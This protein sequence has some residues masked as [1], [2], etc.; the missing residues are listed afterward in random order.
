MPP[1]DREIAAAHVTISGRESGIAKAFRAVEDRR[2][3]AEQA[4]KRANKLF[5]DEAKKTVTEVDKLSD[6]IDRN[7]RQIQ[8][9]SKEGKINVGVEQRSLKDLDALEK[10]IER[11]DGKDIDVTAHLLGDME[12]KLF[13]LD[14]SVSR[15]D[16][17][18]IN[19]GTMT[20]F[21]ATYTELG[22]LEKKLD[23]IDGRKV[24]IVISERTRSAL[25]STGLI[26][27][28]IRLKLTLMFAKLPPLIALFAQFDSAAFALAGTLTSLV[29]PLS[30]VIGEVGV[31]GGTLETAAPA[32]LTLYESLGV[33]ASAFA[34][35]GMVIKSNVTE[36][37]KVAKAFTEAAR[38]GDASS[39]ASAQKNYEQLSAAQK[40]FVP[41]QIAANKELESFQT[42]L[43]KP[44][45]RT[46]KAGLTALF[47]TLHNLKGI[48]KENSDI[49][50]GFA[51]RFKDLIGSSRFQSFFKEFF[52]QGG[53][54]VETLER[55][56]LRLVDAFRAIFKANLPNVERF[57]NKIGELAEEFS[58]FIL[59]AEK[60]GELSKFFRESGDYAGK[61]FK[62]I[63]NVG[64][65]FLT[66]FGASREAGGE[67]LDTLVRLTNRFDNWMTD[68]SDSG[69]L[70][71][72]A[73]QSSEDFN[74]IIELLWQIGR[75][76][77]G[78]FKAALPSG[79][80]LIQELTGWFKDL[81]DDINSITGQ[82]GLQE[83]FEESAPVAK[84]LGESLEIIAKG[85]FEISENSRGTLISA[86]EKINNEL[87][88]KLIDLFKRTS[89]T[90]GPILNEIL[91]DKLAIIVETMASA[92]GPV[93]IFLIG[94]REVLS[95]FEA[96]PRPLQIVVANFLAFQTVLRVF[97][98]TRLLDLFASGI[99]DLTAYFIN[100]KAAAKDASV[101]TAVFGAGGLGGTRLGRGIK[102]FKQGRAVA[103]GSRVAV[104]ANEAAILAMTGADVAST[105]GGLGKAGKVGEGIGKVLGPATRS[106]GAFSKTLGI[107]GLAITAI[108]GS[109]EA[110]RTNFLGITDW[111]TEPFEELADA[112]EN[113]LDAVTGGHGAEAMRDL[114]DAFQWVGEK[115]G[116]VLDWTTK[117]IGYIAIKG[118]P[119]IQALVYGIKLFA[120]ALNA[121]A[122]SIRLAVDAVQWLVQAVKDLPGLLGAATAAVG[123]F[124]TMLAT[125]FVAA[126]KAVPGLALDGL[127]KLP[128]VI[129][130]A[131]GLALKAFFFFTVKAPTYIAKGVSGVVR[132]I[133]SFIP[134]AAGAAANFIGAILGWFKRLPGRI[135]GFVKDAIHNVISYFTSSKGGGRRGASAFIS[136]IIEAVSSL[137]GKLFN[138]AK[139]AIR[140]FANGIKNGAHWAV[141]AVKGVAQDVIDFLKEV[142]AKVYEF[143]KNIGKEIGEG[144]KDGIGDISFNIGPVEVGTGGVH[145]AK[146]GPVLGTGSGDSVHAR[147]TPG[148]HVLTKDEVKAAG[149]H[150]AVFALRQMLGGGGQGRGGS[151]AAGG[152]VGIGPGL[153]NLAGS[154]GTLS[155][156]IKSSLRGINALAES[157]FKAYQETVE[158]HTKQAMEAAVKHAE[159]TR[160]KIKKAM[161]E[162]KKE[163]ASET[164]KLASAGRANFKKLSEGA[165]LHFGR[166]KK[167]ATK[168]SKETKD[169]VVDSVAKMAGK[170]FDNM[171][172]MSETTGG[173]FESILG[174]T[175]KILKAFG[176][177]FK[178]PDI[179][180]GDSKSNRGGKGGTGNK[181]GK[182]HRARGGRLNRIWQRF[183]EGGRVMGDM[184]GTLRDVVPA[185]LGKNEAVITPHQEG[186]IEQVSGV[187]GIVDMALGA[188]RTPNYFPF[189]K[190]G[191]GKDAKAS[192]SGYAWRGLSPAGL[193][194][195]IRKV[196]GAVMANFPG[197][198]VTSTTGG[199]HS[200]TSEHYL[201]QAADIAGSSRE[202]EHEAAAWIKRT[203]L[204]KVLSEGIHNPNLSV[205]SGAMVSP[206]F[207][208]A[209]TW[210]GHTTHLHLAV[211]KFIKGAIGG[212]G[213][214]VAPDF[215]GI[216]IPRVK[217]KGGAAAAIAQSA[218]QKVGKAANKYIGRKAGAGAGAD[219]S[220]IKGPVP[221][222]FA[223]VAKKLRSPFRSTLAL[224]EAG[225]AESGMKDLGYGDSSSQGPLQLL[226]STAAG[227]GVSPH[228]VPGVAKL[229][230][231]R[232]FYGKGGAIGLA[233]KTSMPAHQIA[234]AVQG[235]AFSD[236]SNYLAQKATALGL[237]RKFGFRGAAKGGRMSNFA[238]GSPPSGHK[239]V[240]EKAA[241]RMDKQLEKII[242]RIEKTFKDKFANLGKTLI[243]LVKGVTDGAT[244]SLLREY[245]RINQKI[246]Q[247][248]KQSYNELKRFT[249]KSLEFTKENI[250]G[251]AQVVSAIKG[252][253]GLAH[254][255]GPTLQSVEKEH[256]AGL[257]DKERKKF[258]KKSAKEQ[259]E[260]LKKELEDARSEFERMREA[261]KK[262]LK[263]ARASLKN[264]VETIVSSSTAIYEAFQSYLDAG[265]NLSSASVSS[266]GSTIEAI[267]GL[268]K[269]NTKDIEQ[270]F[271]R[272]G[273]Y[274]RLIKD[275]GRQFLF[276]RQSVKLSVRE[277]RDLGSQLKFI[278]KLS[279]QTGTQFKASMETVKQNILFT[280]QAGI[281]SANK[282][283]EQ[284]KAELDRELSQTTD[285]L[286]ENR[287]NELKASEDAQAAELKAGQDNHDAQLKAVEEAEEKITRAQEREQRRREIA[288]SRRNLGKLLAKEFLSED[289]INQLEALQEQLA[290]QLRDNSEAERKYT[291]E[292]QI[293][294]IN[295]QWEAQEKQINE[296]YEQQQKNINERYD[297]AI[298]AAQEKYAQAI[299]VL[300]NQIQRMISNI[301]A[302]AAKALGVKPGKIWDWLLG[303]GELTKKRGKDSAE[304][305]VK[306]LL[307]NESLFIQAGEKAMKAFL[308]G[309]DAATKGQNAGG[310]GGGGN[311]GGGG[312]GGGSGYS[313]N[314]THPHPDNV[315][316]GKHWEWNGYHWHLVGNKKSHSGEYIPLSVRETD[317]TVT[318]GEMIVDA[319]TV[320]AWGGPSFFNMLS[321][322]APPAYSP[323]SFTSP[324]RSGSGSAGY[325]P[326]EIL[327]RFQ[328]EVAAKGLSKEAEMELVKRTAREIA[329]ESKLQGATAVA[330]PQRVAI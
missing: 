92:L 12:K 131:L 202:E 42:L 192:T 148:E 35:L 251:I 298:K 228:D 158:K 132:S 177:D 207:W 9:L 161:Q 313:K 10:R 211:E 268:D 222:I 49:V 224:F 147:L 151:F 237:M 63:G 221:Y 61:L 243:E 16:G 269:L 73:K 47:G 247:A 41:V 191:R 249:G 273:G 150:R 90:I 312:G 225:L 155:G 286:E 133:I 288:L 186:F 134:K 329:K 327:H 198:Q 86:L 293:S 255:K 51:E 52:R 219:V 39:L 260:I 91:I 270:F 3:A 146:G 20:D 96:L 136:G 253:R 126:L 229:F 28:I 319:Q 163:T 24:D 203:G 285:L 67:L 303:G 119:M 282:M 199:E 56:I 197:L 143:G 238:Q 257:D 242:E 144:I 83:F 14:R 128:Y 37:Q 117:L 200:A 145:F 19:I 320:K 137:P 89:E 7:R 64:H 328:V 284:G 140:W 46:Y 102:G 59:E 142:P 113:F 227:L 250:E 277:L 104:D 26:F 278:K 317:R 244:S 123:G 210:A 164:D 62:I 15:I 11:L 32:A 17:R 112:F 226:A 168:D 294:A 154:V 169:N 295:E 76:F 58:D 290:Q 299:I 193:K 114:G 189:A 157:V 95:V 171:T 30:S 18:T 5:R 234:Q 27:D 79:R 6:A 330:Q 25:G 241:D 106:F 254:R 309:A 245:K 121:A 170:W 185:M 40:A 77:T 54:S 48:I 265:S 209:S 218:I 256:L 281:E 291:V 4:D 173:A 66:W 280:A 178:L 22:L 138:W 276:A 172:G 135:L 201:G 239:N 231:T 167:T 57:I 103:T 300:N 74:G 323:V 289:D 160:D 321:S 271:S 127:K 75:V 34:P 297:G 101:A 274:A 93:K 205:Q 116:P 324:S 325:A 139:R 232:G 69:E 322:Y 184:L 115:I 188:V 45:A 50:A 84:L 81:A 181:Q 141:E 2:K 125:K 236:G 105:A 215:G 80:S 314:P 196:A 97:F 216:K 235:S 230:L 296:R 262:A 307:D 156:T 29:A 149:G 266:V 107:V 180:L 248:Y 206:S 110:L 122:T 252:F 60:T 78:I 118:N 23:E 304:H 220:G 190:G 187:P 1:G 258:E 8:K 264:I 316:D 306:G 153:Q 124:A 212:M 318:G 183:A 195:G 68:L 108:I 305:L 315:P 179:G 275:F 33:L 261:A 31:L 129:G 88:P 204:Y 87:L 208:G 100:L 109:V 213:G 182:V 13:A 259:H 120:F 279:K 217:A 166:T 233:K 174:Q 287:A 162:A 21:A 94:L 159:H 44:A 36:A 246:Q 43:A 223:Q 308:A 99:Q 283:F 263:G 71:E 130:Y 72:F 194:A 98:N 53:K 165:D 267:Q 65:A 311:T 292:D 272:F 111:L 85:L 214:F 302:E 152:G 326:P 82:R 38:S 70:S 175:S 301:V 240:A 310:G 176:V 55:P